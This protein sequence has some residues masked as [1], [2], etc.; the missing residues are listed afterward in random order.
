MRR[1]GSVLALAALAAA[2]SLPIGC[3]RDDPDRTGDANGGIGAAGTNAA[4]A[5]QTQEE[6]RKQQMEQEAAFR[7]LR[8]R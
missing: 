4:N 1:P 3:S 6:A 7:K 2:V 8:R 5:P